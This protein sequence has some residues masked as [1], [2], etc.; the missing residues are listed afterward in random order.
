MIFFSLALLSRFTPLLEEPAL[1]DGDLC[2]QDASSRVVFVL[3]F[4]FL[5]LNVVYE[6]ESKMNSPTKTKP[7]KNKTLAPVFRAHPWLKRIR[8]FLLD[9]VLLMM[10][11]PRK[12]FYF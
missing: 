1:R 8:C 9:W 6:S 4:F 5:F 7:D 2:L 12:Y 10:H 3:N 11:P